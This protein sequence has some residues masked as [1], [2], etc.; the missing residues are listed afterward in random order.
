MMNNEIMV[1]EEIMDAVEEAVVSRTFNE[2][3]VY[4]SVGTAAVMIGGHFL[5]KKVVKPAIQ[6][7]K[8]KKEAEAE[9]TEEENVIDAEFTEKEA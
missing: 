9:I 4:G 8:A 5:I 1:N 2:G 7:I 3:L 6:K